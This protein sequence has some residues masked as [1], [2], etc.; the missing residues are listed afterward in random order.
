MHMHVVCAKFQQG[1]K[2]IVRTKEEDVKGQHIL[3]VDDLVQ[4]DGT[5]IECQV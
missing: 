1:D 3:I 2:Q 5:L 4:S